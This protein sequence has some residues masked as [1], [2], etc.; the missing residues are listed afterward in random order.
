MDECKEN[1][2]NMAKSREP[3]RG[4]VK[5]KKKKGKTWRERI[6][7]TLSKTP[8]TIAVHIMWT[9]QRGP[10]RTKQMSRG[11]HWMLG[12]KCKGKVTRVRRDAITLR[13]VTGMLWQAS[14]RHRVLGSASL[15]DVAR[16]RHGVH[17]HT[18]HVGRRHA[19]VL[20]HGL[21][22]GLRCELMVGGVLGRV[23]LVRVVDAVLV[24]ARRLWRV[25]ACLS[26]GKSVRS[27]F[28]I[29]AARRGDN[30]LT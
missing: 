9:T 8:K 15:L 11:M 13:L 2:A 26:R 28:V 16:V 21:S 27:Q 25:Q 4:E 30:G 7:D 17:W 5:E 10:R 29:G 22:R 1:T 12:Y 24:S 19:V 3:K 23:D 6:I 18:R 20:L 14:L